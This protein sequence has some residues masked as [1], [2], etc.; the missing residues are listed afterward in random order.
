MLPAGC[1]RPGSPWTMIDCGFYTLP[2]FCGGAALPVAAAAS[3]DRSQSGTDSR[4][5]SGAAADI[6]GYC[7]TPG[8]TLGANPLEMH[9]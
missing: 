5:T 2:P 4:G 8:C 9:G 1:R 7:L 6:V 3:S